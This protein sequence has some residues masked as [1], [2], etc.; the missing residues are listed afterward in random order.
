VLAGTGF[1]TALVFLFLMQGAPEAFAIQAKP[2]TDWSY[3]VTS[4]ST[5]DAYTRGCW[6]GNTDLNTHEN[7]VVILDFGGQKSDG[8][9]SLLINGVFISN[10]Q[11]EAVAEAFSHGYWTCASTTLRLG[12]GTNNSYDD[13]SFSG[14]QTWV[15][16]VAAVQ[17]FNKSNGYYPGVLMYGANDMEPSWA[18]ASA[19]INWVHGFTSNPNYG[20]F[21]YGSADGCPQ[22]S[23]NN[24]SCNNGWTQYDVWYV[25]TGGEPGI[26]H[27]TPEIYVPAQ[28]SQ[29]AMISLYAAQHQ[30]GR[31]NIWGP[32]DENDLNSST[33][34]STQAWDQLWTA[35]NNNS[36]T[37]QNLSYSL[38]IHDE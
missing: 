14:G 29:W 37:K 20:Y 35:L 8:S 10:S 30:G 16:D 17:N 24:G 13:V 34:T 21:N 36:A 33:N 26:V 19:T 6:Q 11:I 7:S 5:S 38:Q 25:S 3:Y 18:S 4:S 1:C 2:Q 31:L 22:S 9:G 12:I 27:P 15:D 28:A 23:S 32:M